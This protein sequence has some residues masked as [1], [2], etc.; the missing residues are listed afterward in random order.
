MTIYFAEMGDWIKIGYTA[1]KPARRIA[2]LQTGQPQRIKL[3]GTIP[4]DMDAESSLHQEFRDYRVGGEWF[5]KS[6]RLKLV[7]P[8]LIEN[9]HPWYFC[10]SI[11]V[12]E[13]EW[14]KAFKPTPKTDVSSYD[15]CAIKP[16]GWSKKEAK[17]IRRRAQEHRARTGDYPSWYLALRRN[18][19]IGPEALK[20]NRAWTEDSAVAAAL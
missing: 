6:E 9:Q 8:F 20:Y 15:D 13:E 2:Q 5:E 1:G 10:R 3:L 16:F 14:A 19:D 12:I 7:V 18:L 4:G 17:G 11:R